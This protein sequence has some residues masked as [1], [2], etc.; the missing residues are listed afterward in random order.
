MTAAPCPQGLRVHEDVWGGRQRQALGE[1]QLCQSLPPLPAQEADL[2]GHHALLELVLRCHRAAHVTGAALE[3]SDLHHVVHEGQREAQAAQDVR[4]LLLL[5]GCRG[6]TGKAAHLSCASNPPQLQQQHLAPR[7]PCTSAL[8]QAQPGACT[9]SSGTVTAANN[10]P[11]LEASRQ[12]PGE[13]GEAY[14]KFTSSL[15]KEHPSSV[16]FFQKSARKGERPSAPKAQL[17]FP[18]Q[19]CQCGFHES[20]NLLHHKKLPMKCLL[21][22]IPAFIPSQLSAVSLG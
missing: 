21:L 3:S 12:L 8:G 17:L 6:V 2:V 13:T 20:G 18:L 11:R 19:Q 16:G 7:A 4:V 10:S 14:S 22:Y 1:E 9:G 5:E 15:P